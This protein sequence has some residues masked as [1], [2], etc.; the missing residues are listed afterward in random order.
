M[1][2]FLVDAGVWHKKGGPMAAALTARISGKVR[3]GRTGIACSEPAAQRGC[4]SANA[5]IASSESFTTPFFSLDQA[6]RATQDRHNYSISL[7]EGINP[8]ITFMPCA[9][10]TVQP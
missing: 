4:T 5:P 7:L 8:S 3:H 10:H 1:A 9:Q 2:F 6:S